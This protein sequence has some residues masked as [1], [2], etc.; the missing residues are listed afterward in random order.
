[1]TIRKGLFASTAVCTTRD[2]ELERRINARLP[3]GRVAAYTIVD[4]DDTRYGLTYSNGIKSKNFER[5]RFEIDV[6]AL[7]KGLGITAT[8]M[9]NT[10][11]PRGWVYDVED[12]DLN[13]LD[14]IEW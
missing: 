9:A 1:M 7:I 2:R 3:R 13:P 8:D 10:Q 12:A 6:D 4:G 14:D 5:D 11:L